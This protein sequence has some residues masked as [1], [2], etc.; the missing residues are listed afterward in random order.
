MQGHREEPIA[1]L[2]AK[3]RPWQDVEADAHS[4]IGLAVLLLAPAETQA[5]RIEPLAAAASR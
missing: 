1:P 3:G 2:P 4:S 5:A